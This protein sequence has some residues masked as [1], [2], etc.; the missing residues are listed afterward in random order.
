[1]SIDDAAYLSLRLLLGAL[2]AVA[3]VMTVRYALRGPLHGGRLSVVAV[4]GLLLSFAAALSVFDGIKNG[5]ILAN[6]PIPRISWMWL[7]GFDMLLPLWAFLLLRAWRA[8]DEAEALLARL[9]V[10][11]LLTNVLN[12]R[13]FHEQAHTAIAQARRSRTPVSI[14]MFDIDRFKAVNDG[15][16]HDAGDLV[17]RGFAAVLAD[18]IRAADILGRLGGEE[19]GLVMPGST[20]EQALVLVERLRAA[21]R[22]GVPHPAGDGRLLTVSAGIALVPDMAEEESALAQ[23]LRAADQALYAAKDQGRDRAL[24][25]APAALAAA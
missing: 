21:V 4:G 7:L 24:I 3:A 5:I 16:G 12:R 6:E 10:T 20:P 2:S 18:G 19:F 9:A 1:M 25:A 22:D 13:G 15:F 17:L 8:R 14:A 11:D 23:A